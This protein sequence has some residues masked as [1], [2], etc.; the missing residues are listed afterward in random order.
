ML[1]DTFYSINVAIYEYSPPKEL[2][3][4][5]PDPAIFLAGPIQGAPNWQQEAVTM[6]AALNYERGGDVHVLNP[7]R[8]TLEGDFNYL[9]QVDWE[10]DGLQKAAKFGSVLFWFAARDLKSKAQKDRCYAQTSRV[11]FGMLT[12][13]LDYVPSINVSIGI[14]PGYIGSEKY[15]RKRAHDYRMPVFSSLEDTCRDALNAL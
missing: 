10:L 13:W 12:G 2:N 4:E 11:E 6:F 3:I 9:E 7:R 15:F 8:E 5:A 1:K 14:E